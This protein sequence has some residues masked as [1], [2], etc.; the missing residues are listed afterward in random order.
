MDEEETDERTV[1]FMRNLARTAWRG[2]MEKWQLALGREDDG[3]FWA[4]QGENIGGRK[5]V[6]RRATTDVRHEMSKWLPEHDEITEWVE[7]SEV[8]WGVEQW[9]VL[10]KGA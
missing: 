4:W 6:V 9:V 5:W 3:V 1:L 2:R 7:G 8:T 10:E